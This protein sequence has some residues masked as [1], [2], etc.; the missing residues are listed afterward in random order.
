MKDI[1]KEKTGMTVDEAE[2]IVQSLHR[3]H[4]SP[5]YKAMMKK[6][7]KKKKPARRKKKPPQG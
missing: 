5:E 4:E 1:W 2:M 3:T 7:K 6:A